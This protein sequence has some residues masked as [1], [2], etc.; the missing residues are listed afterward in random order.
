MRSSNQQLNLRSSHHL[1]QPA[2][3]CALKMPYLP[4][5]ERFHHEINFHGFYT[6]LESQPNWNTPKIYLYQKD[7]NFSNRRFSNPSICKVPSLEAVSSPIKKLYN[8]NQIMD[9]KMDLISFQ[10]T[11]N[12]EKSPRKNGVMAQLRKPVNPVLQL[13]NLES[14][15]F[16]LS[17]TKQWRPGEVILNVK[18]QYFIHQPPS[19]LPISQPSPY[20]RPSHHPSIWGSVDGFVWIFV[21]KLLVIYFFMSTNM[22]ISPT[23]LLDVPLDSL[24]M[25]E[26]IFGPLLPILT[27]NNLKECFHVIHSRPKPLAAYLFTKDH[28]LKERFAKTV[29]AES[30]V[31]NDTAVHFTLP[32]LPFGGVGESGIGSYHGKFS[33]DAFSHK[34]SVL[35][36]SFLGDSAIRYPP[37][38]RKKLRLLKALVNLISSGHIQSPFRFILKG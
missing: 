31:V 18:G 12:G 4:N 27:L 34:K 2:Y 29:S 5:P 30:I 7:M 15:W 20:H 22:K 35:F 32:T 25:S 8:P 13:P 17:L 9:F 6:Q 11:K 10:Q 21:T 23:I 24:I 38:S 1:I 28:K 14:H 3:V 16:H 36:K 33:F 37:Y 19:S 26:E